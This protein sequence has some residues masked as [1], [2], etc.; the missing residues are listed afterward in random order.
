MLDSLRIS[1][2]FFFF[3]SLLIEL[4]MQ[5]IAFDGFNFVSLEPHYMPVKFQI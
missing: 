2:V 4:I 5:S 3:L 1:S